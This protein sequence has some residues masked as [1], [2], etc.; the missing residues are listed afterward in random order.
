MKKK[1]LLNVMFLIVVFIGY[2]QN[3]SELDRLVEKYKGSTTVKLYTSQGELTGEVEIGYNS[4]SIPQSI[5]ISSSSDNLDVIAEFLSQIILQKEEQGY[6]STD[7]Y[8]EPTTVYWFK[9]VKLPNDGINLTYKKGNMYFIAKGGTNYG[10][11][12]SDK[13]EYWMSI[14]TGDLKRKGGNDGT[15]FD[16]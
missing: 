7:G 8:E 13:N 9:E 11:P 14:E 12:Y 6:K 3:T 10:V 4:D 1:L 15:N 16:F 5:T 2:S